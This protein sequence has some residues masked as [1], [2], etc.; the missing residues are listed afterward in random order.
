MAPKKEEKSGFVGFMS[1]MNSLTGNDAPIGSGPIYLQNFGLVKNWWDGKASMRNSNE[2]D[3]IKQA[4]SKLGVDAVLVIND[5]DYSFSCEA[6]VG[7]TGSAST[8]SA[9]TVSLVDKSGKSV[10]DVRQWFGTSPGSAAIVIV[11]VNPLQQDKL[12]KQHGIKTA[13]LF[14][15]EF[16]D[17]LKKK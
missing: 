14:A 17:A 1:K 3:Y 2:A 15:D 5:P 10:L 9:F 8:G 12:F 6:C 4:I 7:G 16:K 13:K 11:I